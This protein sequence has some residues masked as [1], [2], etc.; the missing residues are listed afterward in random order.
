MLGVY[1]R[2]ALRKEVKRNNMHLEKPMTGQYRVYRVKGE[3]LLGTFH[4]GK[5]GWCF[6]QAAHTL[7]LDAGDIE[8]VARAFKRIL[9]VESE[10]K[11]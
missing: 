3:D 8:V 11:D 9:K 7:D 6:N 10:T 1:K 4:I 5:S 2:M